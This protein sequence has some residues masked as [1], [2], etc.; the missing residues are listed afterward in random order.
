MRKLESG[1][2]LVNIFREC[3]IVIVLKHGKNN[4]LFWTKKELHNKIK[5]IET[6]DSFKIDY[7]VCLMNVV[8]EKNNGI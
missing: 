3:Q 1:K 8:K 7:G 2:K 5:T 4:A 6:V